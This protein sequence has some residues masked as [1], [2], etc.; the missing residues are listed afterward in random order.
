MKAIVVNDQAAG[1]A[2]MKLMERPEPR[3]ATLLA[4]RDSSVRQ[5]PE[6]EKKALLY[7]NLTLHR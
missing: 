1:T 7:L 2:G 4:A 5:P 3:A 6:A